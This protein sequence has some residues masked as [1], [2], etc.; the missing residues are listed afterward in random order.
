MQGA[1]PPGRWGHT[2]RELSSDALLL[3]GGSGVEG[4]LGDAHVLRLGGE[5]GARW[6]P[7]I[8]PPDSAAPSPRSWHGACALSPRQ[9]WAENAG[10]ATIDCGGQSLGRVAFQA[11]PNGGDEA[12]LVGSL[13]L[14]GVATHNCNVRSDPAANYREYYP[15]RPGPGPGAPGPGGSYCFPGATGC[16]FRRPQDGSAPGQ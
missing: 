11:D 3:F 5:A 9:L 15:G 12:A 10:T 6:H 16:Q 2:L 8:L 13:S 7:V 14:Q 4:P 1:L